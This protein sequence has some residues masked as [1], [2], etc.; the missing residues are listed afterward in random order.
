MKLWELAHGERDEC[1]RTKGGGEV[2]SLIESVRGSV[3]SS[4][5]NFGLIIPTN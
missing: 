2:R 5:L 4:C 3:K 1:Q